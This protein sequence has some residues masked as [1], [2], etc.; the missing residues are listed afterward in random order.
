[1]GSL[2]PLSRCFPGRF[3]EEWHRALLGPRHLRPELTVLGHFHSVRWVRR[4]RDY[5]CGLC[6]DGVA[7]CW[8]KDDFGQASPP[9]DSFSIFGLPDAG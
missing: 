3:G 2:S 1:M 5:S 9:T 6:F 8:G 7:Y 4:D